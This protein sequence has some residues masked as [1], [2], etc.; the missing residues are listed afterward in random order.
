MDDKPTDTNA[1]ATAT[2]VEGK[3][4][5]Q[6]EETYIEVRGPASLGKRSTVPYSK[7]LPGYQKKAEEAINRQAIPKSKQKRVK[8]YFNSLQKG[9]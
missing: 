2:R 6:G 5:S 3:R 8:E 1:K 4:G 9:K 7:A